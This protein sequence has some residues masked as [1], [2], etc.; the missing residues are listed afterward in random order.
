M[1]SNEQYSFSDGGGSPRLPSRLALH[2]FSLGL[3]GE[4]LGVR[5]RRRG[6]HRGRGRELARARH[7]SGPPT[8]RELGE[9]LG[10]LLD[11]CG[12]AQGSDRI[13]A[14]GDVANKI[15]TYSSAVCAKANGMISATY[16]PERLLYPMMR[17]GERGE[18][19]FKRV[20]WDEA[21]TFIA[22]KM[23][24]SLVASER[25]SG[26]STKP[27]VMVGDSGLTEAVM[28]EKA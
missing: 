27:V 6:L 16:Y 17:V 8:H 21:L 1:Q 23:I 24:N 28:A 4:S 10:L 14:N 20:S 7:P 15:G 9:G 22:K 13:A 2:R 11:P 26:V 3:F 25:L 19:K 5:R 12:H 18:G